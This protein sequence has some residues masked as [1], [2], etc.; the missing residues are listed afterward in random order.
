[1][2]TPFEDKLRPAAAATVV[3]A[4]LGAV[5]VETAVLAASWVDQDE[6]LRN[7]WLAG[8]PPPQI[9][10]KLGR[11]VPAI[12]TRAARLG[13][14]RRFA[15]GRK[16]SGRRVFLPQVR[17]TIPKAAPAAA[18]AVAPEQAEVKPLKERICLMCLTKF[19]SLGAYNRICGSCK[20]SN[21][22]Q[23]GARLP[24]LDFPT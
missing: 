1:L 18:K 2:T 17:T 11:S 16:S 6:V 22:Y 10:E 7:L 4:A 24:D 5:S 8:E 21:D 13:L 9:A 23:A 14:P 20:D 3:P 12:M 19:P 15:P